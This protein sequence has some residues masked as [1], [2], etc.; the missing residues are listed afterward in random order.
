MQHHLNAVPAPPDPPH[1]AQAIVV[2]SGFGGAAT[3]CRLAQAG[4]SVIVLERGRRYEANDFPA[5]PSDSALLPDLRRWS[6]QHDQGLWDV[7]DLDEIVTVQ[8]AGYGGGS[9]I[10]ANVHLRPPGGIFDER[11]PAAYRGGAS[12]Q[13][14]YDLAAHMLEVAPVSAYPGFQGALIKSDQLSRAARALGRETFYPP[15]AIRYADGPNLHGIAQQACTSCGNCCTGCPYRAKNTLDA[16]YLAAAE[17]HG[18]Q[19]LTQCEVT[20]LTDHGQ[21]GWEV[22]CI[23]HLKAARL[24]LRSRY[25]FLCAGSVHSTRLIARARLRQSARGAQALAGV[26]YFPGGDSIGIVYDATHEQFPSFGPTITTALVHW[27]EES[28]FFLIEDG[29]YG[30]PLDRAMGLLRAPA[31]VGRNRVCTVAPALVEPSPIAA[32]APLPPVPPLEPGA[33]GPLDA[34]LDALTRGDFHSVVAPD[35]YKSFSQFLDELKAPILFPQVVDATINRALRE[36]YRRSWLLKRFDPDGPL[37]RFLTRIVKGL[38][39]RGFG[40]PSELAGH[41]LRAML[42]AGDLPRA[43]VAKQVLGYRSDGSD[44]RAMFLAMGRD[45]ASGVLHYDAHHDRLLADL[46]LV[47][48]APGYAREEQLM[49]ELARCLGGELRTNPA[50][51]FFGKPITVHNQGGCRMS[52][53]PEHGVTTDEGQVRGCDGLYV[54]DGSILCSSVGTNP[55]ATILAI[56]ER[57]VL[58]FIRRLKGANWPDDDPSPGAADYRRHREGGRAWAERAR[59]EQWT[60]SPPGPRSAS[61]QSRPLGLTFR[62]VMEG[63]Y[64]PT[65]SA[66]RR[67]AGYRERETR[68]CPDFPVKLELDVTVENLAAFF[69]DERHS[70]KLSGAVTLRL[71][72]AVQRPEERCRAQGTL[73]LMVRRLKPYAIT[74]DRRRAAQTFAAHRPYTAHRGGPGGSRERFMKYDLSFSDASGQSWLLWGY[75]RIRKQPGIDAWRATSSLFCQLHGPF[76]AGQGVRRSSTV[77]GAGVA[78]V[79]LTSFLFQQIPSMKVIPDTVDPAR[80]AWALLSFSRFFFGTLQRIY[81]PELGVALDALLRTPAGHGRAHP[82]AGG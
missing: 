36:R 3:A 41:A 26:G 33:K 52:D 11:W 56:A 15:L 44:H 20:G 50:W 31:W 60:I 38:A 47:D 77:A 34:M 4:V 6:W 79:E 10:Y 49:A 13:S 5:L 51:A 18:A 19:T 23:D 63:Y 17:R 14:Y 72:G 59:A 25:V 16:N 40:A 45:A 73:E 69:E 28:S 62:E 12:L 67:D 29:G 24:S 57:N 65:R 78:H 2:G 53:S 27:E 82:S 46:D 64:E 9:L 61:L 75:K 21:D 35:A 58:T 32:P 66:P 7:V 39:Y 81:L 71:P 8:A 55:S 54:L 37:L 43:D 30:K 48:L 70:M 68:G 76:P 1:D 22:E 80:K 74:D 42:M